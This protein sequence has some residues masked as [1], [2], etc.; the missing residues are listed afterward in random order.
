VTQFE[1]ETDNEYCARMLTNAIHQARAKQWVHAGIY[2]GAIPSK[3]RNL[4]LWY[5]VLA[6]IMELQR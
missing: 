2:L 4:T 1:N 5:G 6:A 3:K